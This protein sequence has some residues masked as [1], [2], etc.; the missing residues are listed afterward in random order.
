MGILI[1]APTRHREPGLPPVEANDATADLTGVTA[2][3]AGGGFAAARPGR[4]GRRP[5]P[6]SRLAESAT[7]EATNTAT[8]PAN[9]RKTHQLWSP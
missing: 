1:K 9:S 3:W 2:S 4:V 8:T 7:A 5:L 6:R